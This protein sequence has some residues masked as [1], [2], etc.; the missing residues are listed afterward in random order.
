MTDTEPQSE[1]TLH[2]P[3]IWVRGLTLATSLTGY[4]YT[5]KLPLPDGSVSMC[6]GPSQIGPR[7]AEWFKRRQRLWDESAS[8]FP[9]PDAPGGRAP[10]DAWRE[11]SKKVD[12]WL[13]KRREW[14]K[15]QQK[16]E[17]EPPRNT[18]PVPPGAMEWL[19]H[20][21][22][23]WIA[24]SID[25]RAQP[26]YGLSASE[27]GHDGEREWQA[28]AF[29]EIVLKPFGSAREFAPPTQRDGAAFSKCGPMPD[30]HLRHVERR[31]VELGLE[32]QPWRIVWGEW[33]RW[34]RKADR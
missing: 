32:L 16:G 30:R 1:L 17:E 25:E 24:A 2:R 8:R 10:G 5:P 33:V 29:E 12:E 28:W 13:H 3:D 19:L 7:Y 4:E 20:E 34:L 31:M 27:I 26:N 22:G 14:V 15:E 21:V 23:H 18:A 9:R 6:G 11:H